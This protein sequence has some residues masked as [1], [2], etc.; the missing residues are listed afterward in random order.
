MRM[1]VIK[2]FLYI[3]VMGLLLNVVVGI[4]ITVLSF[5]IVEG[6]L[7]YI[8]ANWEESYS[9]LRTGRPPNHTPT[10]FDRAEFI[11]N[12]EKRSGHKPVASTPFTLDGDDHRYAYVHYFG[13][14]SDVRLYSS[15]SAV[16][17]ELCLVKV[18]KTREQ[19]RVI[20]V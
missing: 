16:Y 20:S 8:K 5:W 17:F 4:I 2:K 10:L 18:E 12:R 19:T 7:N 3:T 6:K 15:R 1:R 11:K 14:N 9:Y 13:D